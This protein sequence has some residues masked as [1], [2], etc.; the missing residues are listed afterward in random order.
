[1]TTT[2]ERSEPQDVDLIVKNAYL[3]TMDSER[4]LFTNGALAVSS[5]RIVDIGTS[6]DI[7]QKYRGERTIDAGGGVVHP[8]YVDNHIHLMYHV[9]RWGI[10]DGVGWDDALPL[11][12]GVTKFS[13]DE[14]IRTAVTL[15]SLEMARN[16]TTSFLEAGGVANTAVAAEAIE[17]VGIRGLLGGCFVRDTPPDGSATAGFDRDTAF[18]NLGAEL[19]RNNDPDALVRGVVSMS[20]MGSCSVELQL[21]GKKLADERGVIL[22]QHQSY[23]GP[24]VANDDE[25]FGRHPLVH[26]A[27]IGLLGDNCMFSHVNIIRDDEIAPIVE[28]GLSI[29][30]CPMASMLFGVGG[31]FHGKHLELYKQGVNIAL[32]CDSA[33]WTSA[34]DLNEQGFIALLTAREKTGDPGALVAE[35]IFEMA[36]IN[37][38]KASGRADEIGSLEVGKRADLV[39]RSQDMPEALPALDPL[40]YVAYS[41]RSKSV[42]TVVVN[43]N[44]IVEGGKSTQVDE[45]EFAAQTK[46]VTTRL[47]ERAGQQP[48]VGRWPRIS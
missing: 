10:G 45:E 2:R 27:D 46:E 29:S 21:A 38:A 34:F 13:D 14:L 15:S 18:E 32:G 25:R 48:A 1:M 40:R 43:G 42:D 33:N 31:T 26:Y 6:A 37:G 41:S 19:W 22:N 20:G 24:D 8:G 23:Q 44:V 36:T 47:F 35:D 4:R 11:H 3:V 39:I 28:S 5:S 7:S 17:Q 16:G 12:G 9:I 30:W